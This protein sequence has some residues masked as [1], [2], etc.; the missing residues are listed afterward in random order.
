M[1]NLNDF[2][3]YGAAGFAWY[4]LAVL[5]E[6]WGAP[7]TQYAFAV[8]GTFMVFLTAVRVGTFFWGFMR[9]S[10]LQTYCHAE[11]GSWALVTG[12]SDGI[13]RGFVDELLSRG[14]NVLLHGRNKT[15]LEGIKNELAKTYPSRTI[16][17]AVA[18]ASKDHAEDAVVEKVK[19]L[20]GKLVILV[21]NVGGVTTFP[22]YMTVDA[23]SA[24]DVDAQININSRFPVQLTRALL[25]MLKENKPAIVL[26]C[27]SNAGDVGVPYIAAYSATKGFIHAFTKAL[28][29]ELS[30]QGLLDTAQPG[31]LGT[32]KGLLGFQSGTPDLDAVGFVIGNVRS[33]G[34]RTEMPLFTVD[35]RHCARGCL[36]RVGT[37]KA[38]EYANWRQ[39]VLAEMMSMLPEPMLRKALAG[40]MKQRKEVEEKEAKAE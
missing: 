35:A 12:A 17:Y 36:A 19:Q 25:P 4:L 23:I 7:R 8:V 11:T 30:A 3:H 24:A 40:P 9:P 34:N 18:D 6:V 13:G 20:P 2:Q 38:M 5:E 28:K 1:P 16:D 26:N 21:N 10:T 14:F 39:G 31:L 37:R 32:V 33:A 27:G 15:K 22:Q 29:A